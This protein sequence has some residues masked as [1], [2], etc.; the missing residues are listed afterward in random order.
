MIT[1]D[2]KTTAEAPA[3]SG[4]DGPYSAV[5]SFRRFQQE[6]FVVHVRVGRG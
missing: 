3:L 6:F 1:G 5:S 4:V 2:N